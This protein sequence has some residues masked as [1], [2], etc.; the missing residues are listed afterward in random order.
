MNRILRAAG[1]LPLIL[2]RKGTHIREA[3]LRES[4]CCEP[5]GEAELPESAYPSQA[6]V[7]GKTWAN[8]A[9]A[10]LLMVGLASFP[11]CESSKAESNAAP[12]PTVVIVS[13]PVEESVVDFV[14]YTGR[15]DST[16]TVEVRS[17]VTGFL[18]KILFTDGSEVEKDQPLYRIDD[19]EF[20]ADLL[21]ANGELAK[22]KA[23]QGQ[24]TAEFARVDALRKK[25]AVTASQFDQAKASKLMA[26]AAVESGTAKVERAQLNITFS[27]IDAPIA[28][29]I[30]RSQISVGNLVDANTTLLT[31]I[32]SVD[33]MYVYFDVDERTYL[34]LMEQVRQGKLE[35]RGKDRGVP[36]FMGLTTDKAYPYQGTIDFVDNRV[37]PATGT[38]RARGVFANPKPATGRRVLEPGLFARIRVP[39]GKPKPTL[40]V[41]DRAIGTDQA[42]KFVYVV[43]DKNEVVFQLVQL[44]PMHEGLR[45]IT[46]GLR[47][48][49]RVIIDGMQR[50]RPGSVVAPKPGDMRSRPGESVAAVED[51]KNTPEKAEKHGKP[52]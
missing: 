6:W 35:E 46:E 14:D 24:T 18:D 42:R 40:L 26:D 41:T 22:A 23:E 28:G 2:V 11:G 13:P 51:S 37:N 36:V 21:A 7:R 33:P 50:V 5:K 20:K 38:L 17:R 1:G 8:F 31:T 12:A 15:T 45:A 47:P 39:I 9:A 3:P 16:D 34:T 10:C 52:K 19:R 25:D 43:N 27:K 32:V 44:G 49:E 48:G 30:S 29:K 4:P